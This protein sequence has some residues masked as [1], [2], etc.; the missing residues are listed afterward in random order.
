M[1]P[2]STPVCNDR[3]GETTCPGH[4]LPTPAVAVGLSSYGGPFH[5]HTARRCTGLASGHATKVIDVTIA[6][7]PQAA[8]PLPC[9][10]EG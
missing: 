2:N 6:Q 3:P 10:Q 4:G 5:I 9:H 8:T 7:A 1:A